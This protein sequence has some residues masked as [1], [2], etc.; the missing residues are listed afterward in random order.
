M[1]YSLWSGAI[2]DKNVTKKKIVLRISFESSFHADHNGTIP[3]FI[4]Q[5]YNLVQRSLTSAF[6]IP[7]WFIGQFLA[8]IAH[9]SPY[10]RPW[11]IFP[12]GYGMPGNEANKVL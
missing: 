6:P 1:D 7:I 5:S 9:Q 4:S 3:S 2:F 10:Y 11:S 12:N 8:E